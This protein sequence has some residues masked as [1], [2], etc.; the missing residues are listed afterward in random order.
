[1]FAIEDLASMKRN[2]VM[3]STL[4]LVTL[5]SFIAGFVSVKM[6]VCMKIK[7]GEISGYTYVEIK[8]LRCTYYLLI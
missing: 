8:L 4:N 5:C 7:G 2:T 6:K 3:E 1:M